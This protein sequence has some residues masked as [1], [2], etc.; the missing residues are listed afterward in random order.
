M[1]RDGSAYLAKFNRRQADQCNYARVELACLQ[2][3]TGAGIHVFGG[4]VVPVPADR[5]VLL[6]ERF[7]VMN[8]HRAH[9]ITING[10]RKDRYQR[11]EAGV[12]LYE[13]ISGLLKRHS[14]DY[15]AEAQQL[16][17]AMLFNR[18]IHNTDD[19]ER[20]FSLI[21]DGS[22]YRL[23]PAYDMVL[24]LSRGEYHAAGFGASPI[25]RCQVRRRASGRSLD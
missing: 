14:A 17:R 3:A 10:L 12:F 22:G 8:E 1:N 15:L 20:N 9:M 18:A 7:D 11:D 21:N 23:S 16:L 13:S 25:H 6:L 19:H 4:E 24:S 5:E 2:M